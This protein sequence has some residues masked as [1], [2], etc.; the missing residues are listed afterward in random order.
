MMEHFWSTDNLIGFG[1]MILTC[2]GLFLVISSRIN[3]A[4]DTI[5]KR[6]DK[7]KEQTDLRF[8]MFRQEIGN[9]YVRKDIYENNHKNLKDMMDAQLH[10]IQ[11]MMQ[12]EFN[13]IKKSV[14][15]E[16]RG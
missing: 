13:N 14:E 3:R 16:K 8:E 6:F 12:S 4:F 7:Y 15:R 11:Q 5:F 2:I 9:Q 10:S 1:S